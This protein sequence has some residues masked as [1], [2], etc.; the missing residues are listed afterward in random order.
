MLFG[1]ISFLFFSSRIEFIH[2]EGCITRLVRIEGI[3]G[4]TNDMSNLKVFLN[5][6]LG[7]HFMKIAELLKFIKY[8]KYLNF[9]EQ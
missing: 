3:V 9:L 4:A 8:H 6:N 5:N 1:V 7:T 2:I